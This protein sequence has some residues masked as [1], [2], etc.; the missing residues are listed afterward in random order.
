MTI[1]E[2]PISEGVSFPAR[3]GSA[4]PPTQALM[5]RVDQIDNVAAFSRTKREED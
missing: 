2:E 5:P 3:I 1:L 4:E